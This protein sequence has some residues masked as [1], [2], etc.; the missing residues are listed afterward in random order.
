MMLRTKTR[1][2]F[3]VALCALA[4]TAAACGGGGGGS[5]GGSPSPTPTSRSSS[6]AKISIVEPKNGAVIHG[7]SLQLVVSLKGAHVVKPT[8]T[9][10]VPTQGH[11]HV[12]LDN[13]IISMNYGLTQKVGGLKPGTH[14]LQTEFVAS[15]HLPWNPR[16][17]A[18]V[19][20]TVKH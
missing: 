14:V 8:T 15:D 18:A 2:T 10:I 11:I 16:I 17:L 12:Y 1:T 19:S 3:A 20:F 13:K 7:T 4:L 6:P 5:S 9:H